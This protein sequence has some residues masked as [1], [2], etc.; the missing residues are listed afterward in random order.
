MTLME[1]PIDLKFCNE[2]YMNLNAMCDLPY[3][4]LH[5]PHTILGP[6]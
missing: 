4:P 1:V 5:H 6:G 3:S 2:F